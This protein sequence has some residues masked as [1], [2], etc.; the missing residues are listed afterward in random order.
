MHGTPVAWGRPENQDWRFCKTALTPMTGERRTRGRLEPEN[1]LARDTDKARK[2]PL[3][4]AVNMRLLPELHPL[5]SPGGDNDA[6]LQELI[7]KYRRPENTADTE[8]RRSPRT[9]RKSFGDDAKGRGIHVLIEELSR[10]LCDSSGG[11]KLASK[12]TPGRNVRKKP[13]PRGESDGEDSDEERPLENGA[14]LLLELAGGLASPPP[15]E[16]RPMRRRQQVQRYEPDDAPVSQRGGNVRLPKGSEE[17]EGG[18]EET[19]PDERRCVIKG[20]TGWRCPLEAMEGLKH[21]EKHLVRMRERR[22]GPRGG[23]SEKASGDSLGKASDGSE[24]NENASGGEEVNGGGAVRGS[25]RRRRSVSFAKGGVD[26]EPEHAAESP[27]SDGGLNVEGGE[28]GQRARR[29]P[30]AK[31]EWKEEEDAVRVRGAVRSARPRRR[32]AVGKCWGESDL[33]GERKEAESGEQGKAGGEESEEKEAAGLDVLSKEMLTLEAESGQGKGEAEVK[34]GEGGVASLRLV[35]NETKD[36]EMKGEDRAGCAGQ[37]LPDKEGGKSGLESEEPDRKEAQEEAVLKGNGEAG[38]NEAVEGGFTTIMEE[39]GADGGGTG[40]PPRVILDTDVV[41][42][43]AV[44]GGEKTKKERKPRAPGEGARKAKSSPGTLPVGVVL[45]PGTVMEAKKVRRKSNKGGALGAG[46][47]VAAQ[48]LPGLSKGVKLPKVVSESDSDQEPI[49]KRLSG[50]VPWGK[51]TAKPSKVIRPI[52]LEASLPVKGEVRDGAESLRPQVATEEEGGASVPDRSGGAKKKRK[53]KEDTEDPERCRERR[54]ARKR[55]KSEQMSE[56]LNLMASLMAHQNFPG[57]TLEA[58]TSGEPLPSIPIS[59]EDAGSASDEEPI[60][61]RLKP[62]KGG[63]LSKGKFRPPSDDEGKSEADAICQKPKKEVRKRENVAGAGRKRPK[64]ETQELSVGLEPSS[65]EGLLETKRS[66]ASGSMESDPGKA[67]PT[68]RKRDVLQETLAKF[69]MPERISITDAAANGQ[70]A[71]PIFAGLTGRNAGLKLNPHGRGIRVSPLL[72]PRVVAERSSPFG[73]LSGPITAELT[74]CGSIHI[75]GAPGGI[76]IDGPQ[77]GIHIEG[78]PGGGVS[79]S[80]LPDIQPSNPA[81]VVAVTC[82]PCADIVPGPGPPPVIGIPLAA[83]AVALPAQLPQPVNIPLANGGVVLP[84]RERA[85]S[86]DPPMAHT[87]GEWEY[88]ALGSTPVPVSGGWVYPQ[89]GSGVYDFAGQLLDAPLPPPIKPP[90]RLELINKHRKMVEPKKGGSKKGGSRPRGPKPRPVEHPTVGEM[91][92]TVMRLAAN[93]RM[94]VNGSLAAQRDLGN[95]W[96]MHAPSQG[97]TFPASP[98]PPNG[99]KTFLG[100]SPGYEGNP[101]Q[102]RGVAVVSNGLSQPA[103]VNKVG[104]GAELRGN[105]WGEGNG[106]ESAGPSGTGGADFE[107]IAG[108][109]GVYDLGSGTEPMQGERL[110][111]AEGGGDAS[112]A[113]LADLIESASGA[114]PYDDPLTIDALRSWEQSLKQDSQ[115]NPPPQEPPRSFQQSESVSEFLKEAE[116]MVNQYRADGSA[117]VPTGAH[118]ADA[119]TG[120]Q[121]NGKPAEFGRNDGMRSWD[122]GFPGV[123]LSSGQAGLPAER[124]DGTKHGVARPVY[125]SLKGTDA[126]ANGTRKTSAES[127]SRRGEAGGTRGGLAEPSQHPRGDGGHSGPPGGNDKTGTFKLFGTELSSGVRMGPVPSA[128]APGIARPIRMPGDRWGGQAQGR[129]L[130]NDLRHQGWPSN[131]PYAI[132]PMRPVPPSFLGPQ[133]QI[134]QDSVPNGFHGLPM[135]WNGLPMRPAGGEP[136]QAIGRKNG[137]EPDTNIRALPKRSLNWWEQDQAALMGVTPV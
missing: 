38:S 6:D 4:A 122:Q 117:G 47:Q 12:R 7:N 97:V 108:L 101:G 40:C 94:G 112:A 81:E 105:Q 134:R 25:P 131:G 1:W 15:G 114:R 80:A 123:A 39:E 50:E 85:P 57:G 109:I 104:H 55:L 95:G 23:A 111:G 66:D 64:L 124:A 61:L 53:R 69:S 115:S 137:L 41:Q 71:L 103:Q 3:L 121:T 87:S 89:L 2:Q 68:K 17:R 19:I 99:M 54:A 48:D 20:G 126:L 29:Q 58:L 92:D 70:P 18:E 129:G 24:G 13:P 113:F 34:P 83:P 62:G 88:G 44:A 31:K 52:I 120:R 82:P 42:V 72:M 67:H 28:E 107:S 63:V 79:E 102:A 77:G 119:E 35:E 65:G 116:A 91:A 125:G 127:R 106:F 14:A 21:C 59:M 73:P 10:G 84:S 32:R 8:V 56:V 93:S 135:L 98:P 5:D 132:P 100:L 43:A 11:E 78:P 136:A 96:A 26:D 118:G 16:G 128:T 45:S 74:A 22:R 133:Q 36:A 46:C 30:Q 27:T 90:K 33:D 49:G 130:V 110:N 60:A 75:D 76:H 51:V 37:T 9:P 86:M